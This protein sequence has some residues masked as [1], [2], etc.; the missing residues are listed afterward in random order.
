M[1]KPAG[2]KIQFDNT[3][4]KWRLIIQKHALNLGNN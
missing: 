1:Q 2:I 4:A 3:E